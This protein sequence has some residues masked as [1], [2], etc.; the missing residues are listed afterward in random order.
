MYRLYAYLFFACVTVASLTVVFLD[1]NW[2]PLIP[3]ILI[4][5]IIYISFVLYEIF[6]RFFLLKKSIRN[7]ISPANLWLSN[8]LN[9]LSWVAFIVIFSVMLASSFYALGIFSLKNFGADVLISLSA[10]QEKLDA[11]NSHIN[12]LAVESSRSSQALNYLLETTFKDK[13]LTKNS[14]KY[15]SNAIQNGIYATL[16]FDKVEYRGGSVPE[17]WA[18]Y[19]LAFVNPSSL[20]TPITKYSNYYPFSF[21]VSS[22]VRQVRLL[23]YYPKDLNGLPIFILTVVLNDSQNVAVYYPK[24]TN[25]SLA[26]SDINNNYLTDS[27]IYGIVNTVDYEELVDGGFSLT[28]KTPEGKKYQHLYKPDLNGEM[29]ISD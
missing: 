1:K 4:C 6:S 15:T 11:I 18:V 17:V 8:L 5:L 12:D 10:P 2:I 9:T 14:Q 7:K 21:E 25:L 27:D 24:N 13:F 20:N 22:T 3:T 16:V 26:T 29:W 19:N 23:G 28:F